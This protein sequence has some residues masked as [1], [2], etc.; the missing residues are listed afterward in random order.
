MEAPATAA[1][2]ARTQGKNW[3]LTINNYSEKDWPWN[4]EEA[5]ELF[6]YA[7]V[8]REKAPTTGTPHMQ[9]YVVFKK[10]KLFTAVKK[11]FPNAHISQAKGTP[12]QNYAYCSKEG[13]FEEIGTIPRTPQ[14]QGGD[15]NRKRY[16]DA[17][18]A[19]TEGRLD[20]IPRD[21]L[22]KH[23]QTYKKIKMDHMI[24]QPDAGRTTGIWIYGETGSGKSRYARE[25]YP[26][27]YLK[28]ANKWWDGYQEEENVIIEDLDPCHSV[29]GH[30]LKLW[31]DRHDFIAE[32]KGASIRIRP[33]NVVI[34]SQYSID[35]VFPELETQA[36]LRRR[37]KVI[38]M[39]PTGPIV[40]ALGRQ[41]ATPDTDS[42]C[43]IVTGNDYQ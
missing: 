20:E 35:K 26:D 40:D 21:L 5:E 28:A 6:E 22:T 16:V 7:I 15:A 23:Y 31:T 34:T 13:D 19:A 36:A 12:A 24:A 30:H 27:Y 37:C 18:E 11:L 43:E 1:P 3:C 33:K 42:S 14:D 17:Y 25:N 2:H 4:G 32:T 8:G 29:L 41:D 10:R 9:C 38:H 39:T